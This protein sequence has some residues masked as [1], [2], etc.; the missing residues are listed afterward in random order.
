MC[1]PL[2]RADAAA[3]ALHGFLASPRVGRFY[4]DPG[5]VG[6]VEEALVAC[7]AEVE[8]VEAAL[9]DVDARL[10]W[11]DAVSKDASSRP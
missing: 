8:R 10:R 9:A 5:A 4:V 6:A 3:V 1:G 11:G 7:V 2:A